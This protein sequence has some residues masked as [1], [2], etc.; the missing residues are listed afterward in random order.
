MIKTSSPLRSCTPGFKS[1]K[2]HIKVHLLSESRSSLPT[3]GV[4]SGNEK[5]LPLAK[6]IELSMAQV[7]KTFKT[8]GNLLANFPIDRTNKQI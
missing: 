3:Q 1:F 6:G 2:F 4:R 8:N 5:F 7:P